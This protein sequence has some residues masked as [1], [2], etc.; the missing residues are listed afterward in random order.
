MKQNLFLKE[1]KHEI[2]SHFR[3][4]GCVSVTLTGD[5][6]DLDPILSSSIN[7]NTFYDQTIL[8]T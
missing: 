8:K 5:S 7:V 6:S 2:N 1:A 3:T 4:R